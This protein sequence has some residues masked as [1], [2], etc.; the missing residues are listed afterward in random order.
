MIPENYIKELH[1]LEKLVNE[2]TSSTLLKPDP[3][4]LARIAALVNSKP[5]LPAE[6]AKLLR[7]KLS[8]TRHA[9]SQLLLLEQIEFATCRCGAELHQEFH[10]RNFLKAIH[11]VFGMQNLSP[12][13]KEKAFY[14]IQFWE[15][16]FEKQADDFPNF[17][18]YAEQIRNKGGVEF[19]EFKKSPYEL[20]KNDKRDS[21]SRV[22]KAE[23]SKNV[24]MFEQERV[25]EQPKSN[26][27]YNYNKDD[28]TH[29]TPKQQKLLK[30][31]KVVEENIML[32]NELIDERDL[33]NSKTVKDN[34]DVM[35]SKLSSLPDKLS[36]AQD[37]MLKNY[38]LALLTDVSN[39][40]ARFSA[41]KGKKP[42]PPFNGLAEN[43]FANNTHKAPPKQQKS[44]L[45]DEPRAIQKKEKDEE[46]PSR[47]VWDMI[48]PKTADKSPKLKPPK[49]ATEDLLGLDDAKDVKRGKSD[50][51][52]DFDNEFSKPKPTGQL[53]KSSASGSFD[54]EFDLQLT[55]AP[56]PAPA[57][58]PAHPFTPAVAPPAQNS[59]V[60]P[61]VVEMA[62]PKN[63]DPFE[64]LGEI[65]MSSG[66]IQKRK[67]SEGEDV[68]KKKKLD[69]DDFNF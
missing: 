44:D 14:L 45:F 60:T 30:D 7:A 37:E 57:P 52:F 25:P 67:Q 64:K 2:S 58:A 49:K 21:K 32:F 68:T 35:I 3:T 20:E 10:S 1:E 51:P 39:S 18:E 26:S 34:L 50:S 42:I 66:P 56:T 19:P 41:L 11:G 69:E 17:A 15:H 29:L 31:L 33:E 48:A 40:Q 47:D 43:V 53:K 55:S 59:K 8:S 13:V 63:Y 28:E 5:S 61:A 27:Q 22:N 4:R 38:V 46:V 36:S 54:D 24:V 62:K 12:E 16:F 23:V 6:Y 65:D 9:R